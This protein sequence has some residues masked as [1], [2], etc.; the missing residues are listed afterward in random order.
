MAQSS[1]PRVPDVLVDVTELDPDETESDS[2]KS[3]SDQSIDTDD[4]RGM[5]DG[6]PSVIQRTVT[7]D[8]DGVSGDCNDHHS[9][10]DD[11][12]ESTYDDMP[13]LIERR[14]VGADQSPTNGVDYDDEEGEY[15]NDASIV[16]VDDIDYGICASA[17][18]D[19]NGFHDTDDFQFHLAR[20]ELLEGYSSSDYGDYHEFYG[21]DDDDETDWCACPTCLIDQ[22]VGYQ[23]C[24]DDDSVDE[25]DEPPLNREASPCAIC[26]EAETAKRRFVHLP[27]CGT[28]AMGSDPKSGA[29]PVDTSSTRFCQK[30]LVKHL[31]TNGCAVL[32]DTM[33]SNDTDANE[34]RTSKTAAIAQLAGECPRCKKLLVLEECATEESP[35]QNTDDACDATRVPLH[36]SSNSSQKSLS[37]L[38]YYRRTR[39]T[40][41]STEALF[42]YVARCNTRNGGMSDP[43]YRTF[44][45]TMAMCPDPSFIPEEL[46][47][48][49]S[50]SPERIRQLSQWGMLRR[51]QT[52]RGRLLKFPTAVAFKRML[53]ALLERIKKP[54]NC[55]DRIWLGIASLFGARLRTI[56][57]CVNGWISLEAAIS[58]LR[59]AVEAF[60]R[61]PNRAGFVYEI[62]PS[63]Q[64]E[65]R[66]LVLRHLW[67]SVNGD[68]SNRGYEC[69]RDYEPAYDGNGA[70]RLL[71]P[72]RLPPNEDDW[73]S[74]EAVCEDNG[75]QQCFLE[76]SNSFASAWMA[77]RRFRLLRCL[78]LI[79]QGMS[80]GLLSTRFL[81]LPPITDWSAGG[82][83]PVASDRTTRIPTAEGT[84][85]TRWRWHVLSG[86]NALLLHLGIRIA[87]QVAGVAA[88]LVLAASLCHTAGILL[89]RPK[90]PGA[91]T[92]RS[93]EKR[94]IAC[95]V[96]VLAYVS[97]R[98][99]SV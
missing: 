38:P 92:A 93:V 5:H 11:D 14:V 37:S 69:D 30:C 41:P 46:L 74:F 40:I 10:D 36:Q 9:T 27:C 45:L 49:N 88:H 50:G 47:L 43:D 33:N 44:L 6:M 84:R 28:L 34:N 81:G 94:R 66:S 54:K 23:D 8:V 39:A 73:Q 18:D 90:A 67:C 96:V 57:S 71:P 19:P 79:D 26:M 99:A 70:L 1:S 61:L 64:S 75:R 31:V 12:D 2:G 48:N 55:F 65:L 91:R 24:F 58:A 51:R 21:S 15:S 29:I 78:R 42:W 86:L 83:D 20:R 82:R 95:G 87:A 52:N 16:S 32:C 25:D 80:L 4:R 7:D 77:A 76:A 62:D 3:E 89:E 59:S 63:F 56:W 17:V 98:C 53:H 68:G 35:S 60:R 97:W 85:A 22:I 72:P 13:S